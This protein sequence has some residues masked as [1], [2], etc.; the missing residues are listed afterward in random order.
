M[1]TD[2]RVSPL[3]KIHRKCAQYWNESRIGIEEVHAILGIIDRWVTEAEEDM[4]ILRV[5][6]DANFQEWNAEQAYKIGYMEG[7]KSMT[8]A[9]QAEDSE[10][11][12]DG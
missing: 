8:S 1:S 5:R 10:H 2:E 7:Q 3:E 12:S 9:Q 4:A 6:A 11:T